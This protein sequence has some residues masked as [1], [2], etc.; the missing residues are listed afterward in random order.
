MQRVLAAGCRRKLAPLLAL[1]FFALAPASANAEELTSQGNLVFSAER[2]FGFS[3]DHQTVEFAN[4][5]AETDTTSFSLGWGS[6]VSALIIPRLGI[7]Y[8]I[9]RNF[10]LGGNI[11]FFV[12][13]PDGGGTTTGF[14]LGARVGYALRLGHVVSLWPRAGFTY[15]SIGTSGDSADTYTF[16][17]TLDAPFAFALTEGFAFTLGPMLDLGFLAER[18]DR[19]ASEVV[20]GIMFGLTGWTNL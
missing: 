16:A 18:G 14:L 6:P 11:G 15:A 19:D 13:S 17:L 20:F 1:G 9:S 12:N 8:F 5:D 7:D 3:F 2:F 4:T 10:T